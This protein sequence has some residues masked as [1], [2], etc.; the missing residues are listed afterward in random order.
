MDTKKVRTVGNFKAM[1]AKSLHLSKKNYKVRIYANDDVYE[2]VIT[3]SRVSINN[4]SIVVYDGFE[5]IVAVY[6]AP[7]TEILYQTLNDQK[8]NERITKILKTDKL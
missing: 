7:I 8:Q 2:D 3:A 4:N 1:A 5:N 6:P